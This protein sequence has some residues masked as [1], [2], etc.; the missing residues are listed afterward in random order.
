M[1]NRQR[2]EAGLIYDPADPEI[3]AEQV[4]YLDL[5]YE[6]NALRPS[7]TA[8]KR[9]MLSRMF[10]SVGEGCWIEQPFH[11]NFGGKH[12]FMGNGVYAN[13]NLTLVDDGNI[14]IGD[15]VMFGP[16]VTVVTAAHP[17][18]S[19][20][21][22]RAMQFNREVRIERNA[23]I[24]AGAVILPGVTVGENSVV[25]AGSVVTRDIPANSV[26]YGDPCRVAREISDRD[27]EYY[28]KNDKIDW[29]NL[30]F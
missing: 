24:G 23:W 29:E 16:N 18:E 20:L 1:T 28:F 22:S 11:A 14:Y 17:V 19:S 15:N 2:M 7:Q 5:V 21:R 6:Y 8:E 10:G 12:V 26:A 4:R 25:G 30:K 13:F 3:C 9:E 27:R